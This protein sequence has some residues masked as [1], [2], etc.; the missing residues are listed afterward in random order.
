MINKAIQDLINKP[1]G[2]N[3]QGQSRRYICWHFCREVYRLFGLQLPHS[4]SQRELI[5][6]DR[7]IVPNIVLF[8][9]A[10]NWHSGV[11][12]PDGLHFIHACPRNIFDPN[13]TKFIVRKDR[14]TV[15]PYNRI[16][17]GCY[18]QEANNI[19]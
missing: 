7:P 2:V 16:I 10:M 11:V 15:W 17:E 14:L 6:V 5:R 8:H 4:H 1:Y 3:L 19:R 9:V 18:A 12:W 13:P